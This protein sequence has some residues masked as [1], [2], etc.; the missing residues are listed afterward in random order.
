MLLILLI[1]LAHRLYPDILN[2]NSFLICL[3]VLF[4]Y[5]FTTNY[6]G[7]R[8]RG[9][10]RRR[11]R[12]E[13]RRERTRERR[14][15]RSRQKRK[16]QQTYGS[17]Y[18]SFYGYFGREKNEEGGEYTP[19][20]IDLADLK[21]ELIFFG[22][23]MLEREGNYGKE[24]KYDINYIDKWLFRY[25][26]DYSLGNYLSFQ[27]NRPGPWENT[28]RGRKT[29]HSDK[30]RLI[31]D[32]KN[33]RLIGTQN[34]GNGGNWIN[35]LGKCDS[36][37][38]V[39]EGDQ[40]WLN[41]DENCNKQSSVR[42]V[43]IEG[44]NHPDSFPDKD[45]PI[46]AIY[47]GSLRLDDI[48]GQSKVDQCLTNYLQVYNKWAT[49]MKYFDEIRTTASPAE[50]DSNSFFW[51]DLKDNIT[52]GTIEQ[53]IA[54]NV[55]SDPD[56]FRCQ[57][58]DTFPNDADWNNYKKQLDKEVIYEIVDKSFLK[59]SNK[60]L[61]GKTEKKDAKECPPGSWYCQEG[62]AKGGCSALFENGRFPVEDCSK[63]CL[64]I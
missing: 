40:L 25:S 24:R 43:D 44:M 52:K 23:E 6:E 58:F 26:K 18:H 11:E 50:D 2:F 60:D 27:D 45:H 48:I 14:R 13:R 49:T 41:M 22:S 47:I 63:Q 3:L 56:A 37:R 8:G 53:S 57:R 51:T 34:V 12:R 30:K 64:F 31:G 9:R 35:I 38:I 32:I 10:R 42:V 33:N 15:D 54:Y 29:A 17:E 7:L 62:S 59:V 21:G 16:S 1:I 5:Y 20:N 39:S 4:G 28:Y 36:Y 46:V 55:L 61:C 19:E